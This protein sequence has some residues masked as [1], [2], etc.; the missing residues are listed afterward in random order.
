MA[1]S[2]VSPAAQSLELEAPSYRWVVMLTWTGVHTWGYILLETIGLFLPSMREEMGLSPEQE[3]WL[4]AS[5]MIG[6]LALALPAGWLMSRFSPKAVSTIT[7]YAAAALAVLQGMAPVY[8][9]L[10][11]WRFVFGVVMMVREPAG[12]MLTKQWVPAREVVIVNSLRSALWGF[13]AVGFIAVPLI[14]QLL[15][16]NWRMTFYAFGAS[17]FAL[18]VVWHVLGRERRTE[19]YASEMRSQTGTPITSLFRYPELWLV[20][21]GMLGIS[22]TWTAFTTFWPSFMLDEHDISLTLSAGVISVS[23]MVAGAGGIA[24]GFAV[25]RVGRKKTVLWLSGLLA[26]GSSILMLHVSAVGYL[27]VLG[28]LNGMA[29]TLF[30]VV[31]TIPFELKNIK[32]REIAVTMGLLTTAMWVGGVIGP[33]LAGY[34]QGVTDDLGLALT[35]TSL[36]A[37]VMTASG[38]LLPRRFDDK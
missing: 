35:V 11:A 14:M 29:W 19:E 9:I 20:S 32:P 13:V 16:D 10:L 8:W 3:G 5:A 31:M 25:S 22:A 28:A 34:I 37:L 27:M 12:T 36:C 15:D 18:A 7:F 2:S 1:K 38:L 30:P 26:A 4:S 33:V 17:S 24:V 23:G 6:N 21:V